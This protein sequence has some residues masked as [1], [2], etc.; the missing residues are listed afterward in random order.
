MAADTQAPNSQEI[1]NCPKD[2]KKA[3]II[4]GAVI[5]SGMFVSKSLIRWV[6]NLVSAWSVAGSRLHILVHEAASSE[7]RSH[8]DKKPHNSLHWSC[9]EEGI[10]T[11]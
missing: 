9:E 7:Q 4:A 2:S 1:V 8:S 3:G 5:G 11:P 6:N 10:Q